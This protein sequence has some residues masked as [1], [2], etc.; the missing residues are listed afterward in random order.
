MKMTPPIL[1][2]AVL[3]ALCLTLPLS[4]GVNPAPADSAPNDPNQ[5]TAELTEPEADANGANDANGDNENQ[6]GNPV[7]YE[8]AKAKADLDRIK[9]DIARLTA[10]K[11][12]IEAERALATARR[13]QEQAEMLE[14]MERQKQEIEALKA[15]IELA[16]TRERAGIK[17]ELTALTIEG[18]MA[19]ARANVAKAEAEQ[20]ASELRLI[21]SAYRNQIA[22]LTLAVE[23]QQ[24][25]S[26]AREFAQTGPVYLEDPVVDG[27]LVI[28]DRRIALNGSINSRTAD[29]VAER[30]NYFNNRDR[31]MPIFLVIDDSPGGSVMAG[32]KILKAMEGSQAPVY[33]VVKSF[34]A[35]MAACITTLAERSFAYPNAILLHHQIAGGLFGNLTMQQE[36]VEELQ[37]WWRRLAGPVADK[38]GVT[39]E[40]FIKMMYENASTGDWQEF[41]DRAVELKWV[42]EIIDEIEETS[43]LE[44][45]D[46]QQRQQA[47]S[48]TGITIAE[49][50]AVYA[51]DEPVMKVDE[52][53][54]PYVLLPRINPL[55]VYWIYNPDGY[56]R[57][58]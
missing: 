38:M 2:R 49:E 12:K 30:I 51:H 29:H 57:A 21:E 32:Y 27:R 37:E 58:R 56:Y 52:K 17:D 6:A 24:K 54:Q 23:L 43:L 14:Q 4:L 15:E 45:P 48:S 25:E 53:G 3:L 20:A 28:S 33:V 47:R 35:S 1:P 55:D 44:H 46:R 16:E 9:E 34:A 36:R 39:Q 22:E 5:E 11:D 19:V 41:A 13:Q 26:E 10:E 40:E 31:E 42:D 18:Q 8:T 50:G 7:D